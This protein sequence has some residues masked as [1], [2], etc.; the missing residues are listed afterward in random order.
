MQIKKLSPEQIITLNDYPVHNEQVL[1]IYFHI[2]KR[3]PSIICSVPVIHKSSGLPFLKGKTRRATKYNK[4]L[5]AFLRTHPSAEYFLLDGTH[6]TTAAALTHHKIPVMIF[7]KD[8]DI[9]TAQKWVT[10]GKLISLTT[11]KTVN[12]C[13]DI[14]QK[15]FRKTGTFQTVSEKTRKMIKEHIL[16]KYMI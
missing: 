8:K 7:Q 13:L 4:K 15:H 10:E 16:P 1:K 14:L 3:A 5:L 6:R 11:G 2:F 9:K 12:N